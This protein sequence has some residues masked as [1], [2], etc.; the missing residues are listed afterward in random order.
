MSFF[1]PVVTLNDNGVFVT[2]WANALAGAYSSDE[3]Y[4]FITRLGLDTI[5]VESVTRSGDRVT[6]DA[7][8]RF[9]RVRRRHTEIE[10][11][12]D[13]GIRHLVMD[14]HTPSE[15]ANQLNPRLKPI[16]WKLDR[17]NGTSIVRPSQP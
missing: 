16:A 12:P 3:R 9:P 10:L 14:I 7:V 11:R 4:G 2:P 5:A 8:D 1:G 6:S 17:K 15:P 13:G